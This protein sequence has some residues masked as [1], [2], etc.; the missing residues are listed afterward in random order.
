MIIFGFGS[1]FGSLCVARNRLKHR[2]RHHYQQERQPKQGHTR[3]AEVLDAGKHII[4][5]LEQRRM[6]THAV[7]QSN[8]S[9]Q[10]PERRIATLARQKQAKESKEGQQGAR[11]VVV[12]FERIVAPI[13]R[14]TALQLAVFIHRKTHKRGTFEVTRLFVLFVNVHTHKARQQNLS[15]LFLVQGPANSVAVIGVAV[16]AT[17]RLR[18][19]VHVRRHNLEARKRKAK[20]ETHRRKAETL[21]TS[22]QGIAME[23]DFVKRIK[24]GSPQEQVSKLQ[25]RTENHPRNR[26][27]KHYHIGNAT[28]THNLPNSEQSK[29][30]NRKDHHLAV[31][32]TIEVGKELRR[33]RVKHAE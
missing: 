21:A 27:R 32:T 7:A 15:H 23:G 20:T 19:R 10:T 9:T 28:R 24:T 25:V 30:S 13:E 29:R 11:I 22:L 33:E 18:C 6:V 26:E 16:I 5:Q 31:V 12:Q 17:H 1:L 14:R 8:D 3:S 4:P 2:A